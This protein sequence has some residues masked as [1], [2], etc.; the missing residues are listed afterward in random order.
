MKQIK[1]LLLTCCA[2]LLLVVLAA[3]V[4]FNFLDVPYVGEPIIYFTNS[5]EQAKVFTKADDS[6]RVHVS[7][8]TNLKLDFVALPEPAASGAQY[9]SKGG[10]YTFWSKGTEACIYDHQGQLMF[11]GSTQISKG[12]ESIYFS[13]S[14]NQWFDDVGVCHSCSPENGFAADGRVDQVIW[15]EVKVRLLNDL[16]ESPDITEVRTLFAQQYAES[17]GYYPVYVTNDN[18]IFTIVVAVPTELTDMDFFDRAGAL[19]ATYEIVH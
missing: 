13:Q 2:I 18:G 12:Q 15:K 17:S 5:G 7:T 4:K 10:T 19:V 6:I 1:S 9:K 14:Q 3:V 11:Q 16:G 8:S